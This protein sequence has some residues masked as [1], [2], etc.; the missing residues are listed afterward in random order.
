MFGD[1]A[2]RFACGS[3]VGTWFLPRGKTPHVKSRNLFLL[4][5][6]TKA[7][8][9]VGW[10]YLF[11]DPVEVMVSNLKVRTHVLCARYRLHI[12]VRHGDL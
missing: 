10:V 4:S 9:D 1:L 2:I 7:F 5:Q 6:M 8:P 12:Y 11:R 3:D